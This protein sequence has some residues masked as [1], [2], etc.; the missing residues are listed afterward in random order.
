MSDQVMIELADL[1][2][3]ERELVVPYGPVAI[4][5]SYRPGAVRQ[6][7]LDRFQAGPDEEDVA[8]VVEGVLGKWLDAPAD[9][10]AAMA[11]EIAAALEKRKGNRGL[12]TDFLVEVLASTGIGRGGEPL[13]IEPDVL[14][15][16]IPLPIL[17][18]MFDAVLADVFP[19]KKSSSSSTRNAPRLKRRK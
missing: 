5:I 4:T 10:L 13:A 14:N 2:A 11:A 6:E 9:D 1:L 17:S 3:D 15:R 12:I 18:A 16:E 19:E 7:M 8:E